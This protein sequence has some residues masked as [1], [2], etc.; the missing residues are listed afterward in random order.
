MKQKFKIGDICRVKLNK[1][2]ELLYG[3]NFHTG[4]L[5]EITDRVKAI[6]DI[7]YYCRFISGGQNFDYTYQTAH[8]SNL[9]LAK[10]ALDY[11]LETLE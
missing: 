2:G 11:I 10:T 4:A 3:L 6:R 7:D 5:V 1:K 9:E 8:Y